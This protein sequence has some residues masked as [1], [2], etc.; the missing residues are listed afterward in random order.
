MKEKKRERGKIRR[1]EF[2]C[3]QKRKGQKQLEV[4]VLSPKRLSTPEKIR[5]G[6]TNEENIEDSHQ[7]VFHSLA[8]NAL[9]KNEQEVQA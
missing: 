3:L 4:T 9:L 7:L 1:L 6:A 2:T 8:L 5:M